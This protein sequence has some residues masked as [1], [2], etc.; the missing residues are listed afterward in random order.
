MVASLNKVSTITTFIYTTPSIYVFH[1]IFRESDSPR[2]SAS[3]N[4]NCVCGYAVASPG[5]IKDRHW[6]LCE[7]RHFQGNF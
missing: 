3:S 4:A 5:R 2:D 1:T 7:V 6:S